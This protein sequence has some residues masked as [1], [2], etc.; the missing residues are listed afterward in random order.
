MAGRYK[1]QIIIKIDNMHSMANSILTG[2]TN[3]NFV[4]DEMSNEIIAIGELLVNYD[5]LGADLIVELEDLVTGLDKIGQSI[6]AGRPIRMPVD[7]LLAKLV[8]VRKIFDDKIPP[9]KKVVYFLPYK[10]SMWDSLESVWE[11][12]SRDES[13][14][15]VVMP[16]PYCDRNPDGTAR[17][18]HWE[19]NE[20]PEYVPITKYQDVDLAAV[21]PDQ[22]YIHN[23]YDGYN[24]VTSVA[25][26]YYSDKLKQCTDQLVYIPYFVS[27]ENGATPEWAET[28][29]RMPVYVNADIIVQQSEKMRD[30]Y[31]QALV[32]LYGEHTRRIWEEKIKG[33]GSPKLDKVRKT[34]K[35]EQD[36]PEDW[37]V[38]IK[39]PDG[40][41]KKVVM[42]GTGLGEML[43]SEAKLLDK[44][45]NV[46]EY[47]QKKT[48]NVMLLWRPHPLIPATLDS[49][50]PELAARYAKIVDDYKKAD[51]G[52][53]DDT[54]DLNRSIA[55]CDAYYG[56]DSSVIQLFQGVKKPVMVEDVEIRN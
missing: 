12:A 44:I 29:A 26:E 43:K 4:L 23:P 5:D 33:W 11:K 48:E 9:N 18:W 52:I 41:W 34:K 32:N 1:T 50:R 38:K 37:L 16:I 25:P 35:D 7:M 31:I 8:K 21:H 30:I 46:L 19:G 56:D 53:F 6:E 45:E 24:L 15:A 3:V 55:I 22:I 2:T 13:C 10:A 14:D 49:M 39:K 42:Y 51:W 20:F 36:L 54:P 28:H 40:S 47:F 27:D 17:E